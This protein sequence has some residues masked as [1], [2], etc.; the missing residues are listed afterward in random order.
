MLAHVGMHLLR[1]HLVRVHL[2]RV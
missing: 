1:V 2:V